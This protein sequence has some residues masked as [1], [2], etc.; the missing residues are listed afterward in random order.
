MSRRW[1]SSPAFLSS[2]RRRRRWRCALYAAEMV[3]LA[4]LYFCCLGYLLTM[5]RA[6]DHLT[7][8]QRP[9]ERVMGVALLFFGVR[10]ALTLF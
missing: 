8:F 4:T 1:C 7:R 6:R 10:V 9:M 3:L 2:S 5:P